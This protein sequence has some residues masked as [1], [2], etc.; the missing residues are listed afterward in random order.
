MI[1]FLTNIFVDNY[2]R[3]NFVDNGRR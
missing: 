2:G 3:P 1:N